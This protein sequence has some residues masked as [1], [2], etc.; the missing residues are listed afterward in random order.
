MIN[1]YDVFCETAGN[2]PTEP[3]LLGPGPGDRLSYGQ[4][5][6]AIDAAAERLQVAGLRPGDCVGLHCPSGVDY[7]I[8]TYAVWRCRAC[9]VPIPV[10]LA[11]P[12]KQEICR[13]I[14]LTHVIT[15]PQRASFVEPLRRGPAVDLP[16]VACVPVTALREHPDGFRALSSA[17]IRFTSGTTGMAKGVVLSHE[18]IRDRIAAANDVLRIGPGDRVVWILS[19]SYHFAVSIVSYLSNG[20]TIVLPSNHFAPAIRAAAQQHGAT[21]IYAA[22][23]HYAWLAES[24]HGELPKSLRLAI[25]TSTAMERG[26]AEKFRRRYG[27]SL[28]Q[29]LGIIEVGLPFINT[30]FAADRPEAVGRVLPA[31]RLRLED[32]GLG[33]HLKEVL[34]GGKG[35]LDAYYEPWCP[36]ERIMPDGWFRTGDVGELDA[37]GCLFLRGRTK[38]LI[39]VLGAKFFPQEV[40]TVLLSHPGVSAASVFAQRDARLGEAPCARVV[41]AD[42]AAA[43]TEAELLRYCRQRLAAFKI[44]Q[45]IEF[46]REL[47]RTASGKVLHRVIEQ[48]SEASP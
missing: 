43:P 38:D 15:G 1:L 16:N 24:I 25:S 42:P 20:A 21:L 22:P 6:D 47:P 17:F 8:L 44:P 5:T 4:L 10:E 2:Q 19:M 28:T 26:V 7:I 32:T 9:V 48:R 46:V 13:T 27:L 41:A 31:Y 39:S 34:L 3:A 29:A 30:D 33:P 37:D 14:A 35:F 11:D 18:T 40:E 45:R 23:T 12:E 36:R